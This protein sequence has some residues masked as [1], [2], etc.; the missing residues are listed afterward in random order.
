[1]D[2]NIQSLSR[3][4]RAI[5][6]V[7]IK[8]VVQLSKYDQYMIDRS[9]FNHLDN[10]CT[11]INKCDKLEK[12]TFNPKIK[13]KEGLR[14]AGNG[15]FPISIEKLKEENRQLYDVVLNK[16]GSHLPLNKELDDSKL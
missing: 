8:D 6:Q 1:M 9:C 16:I 10:N 12:L 5:F 4:H 13:T 7:V 3:T 14:C 15:Y 11:I 2:L